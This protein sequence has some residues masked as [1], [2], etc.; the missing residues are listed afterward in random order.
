MLLDAKVNRQ[1]SWKTA[2]DTG[3]LT[4]LRRAIIH[5]VHTSNNTQ[6]AIRGWRAGI[7]SVSFHHTLLTCYAQRDDREYGDLHA[8]ACTQSGSRNSQAISN[9]LHLLRLPPPWSG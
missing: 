8:N 1:T 9:S 2:Q 4:R 5:A 3:A 7:A 6:F